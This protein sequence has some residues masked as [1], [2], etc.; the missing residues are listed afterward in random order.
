M[1][2]AMINSIRSYGGGEKRVLR[3]AYEF[4]RRGH[5]ILII[6]RKGGELASRARADGFEV[7]E[8]EYRKHTSPALLREVAGWLREWKPDVVLG[9]NEHS[10][11]VGCV[12]ARLARLPRRP[13]TIYYHGL[14]ACFKNKAYNHYLVG[15]WTDLFVPNAEALAEELRNFG[16]ISTTKIHTIYDGVEPSTIDASDPTGVRE[17]LGATPQEVIGVVV[18]RLVPEKGH[19]FLFEQLPNVVGRHPELRLWIA[20]EGPELERLTAQVKDLG[21]AECVRFLGFR[22]DVPR[23]LRAADLLVH[24]SRKEGAPNAVRE[25]MVAGLPVVAVAA[26]GTPELMVGGVTGLLSAIGDGP[27]LGRNLETVLSDPDLR[28]RMGQAG[29]QRALTE[30]SEDTCAERWLALMAANRP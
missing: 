17:S 11:R 14:E 30:F 2:I 5:P 27:E 29:R 7:Q 15:P 8:F 24:P 22:D 25:G 10:I 28:Q 21:L 4:K 16:W 26:S 19:A 18:A 9:W 1:R 20:G 13:L 23:L 12:A 6:A 3:S